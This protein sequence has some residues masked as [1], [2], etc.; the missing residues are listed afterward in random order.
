MTLSTPESEG[1]VRSMLLCAR[2]VQCQAEPLLETQHRDGR[3]SVVVVVLETTFRS[4]GAQ[5]MDS[6]MVKG[7]YDNLAN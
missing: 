7:H 5:H 2:A 1:A 4:R 6:G 3:P